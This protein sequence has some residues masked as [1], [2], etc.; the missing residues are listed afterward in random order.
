MP[1]EQRQPLTLPSDLPSR[2]SRCYVDDREFKDETTGRIVKYSRL[3]SEFIVDGDILL[4][5]APLKKNDKILLKLADD[6]S[7]PMV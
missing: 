1:N 3:V 4:F 2:L 5:E 6:F 7:R